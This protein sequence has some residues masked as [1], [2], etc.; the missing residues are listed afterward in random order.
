M[1]NPILVRTFIAGISVSFLCAVVGVFIVARKMAFFVHAVSHSALTGVAIGYL[2]GTSPFLS[3]IGFGIIAGVSVS[4]LIEKSK[5]FVDTVIGIL[6]PFTMSIGLILLSFVRGY[7]PDV[8]SYLF[9]D[10]LSTGKRDLLLLIVIS[11][12]VISLIALFLKTFILIALDRDFAKIKGYK[13]EMLD[14]LF[15]FVVSLVVLLATKVVGIILVSALVVIPAATAMNVSKSLKETFWLSILFGIFGTALGIFISYM[16]N[17]PTGPAI[18]SIISI[19]FL[20][21][22]LFKRN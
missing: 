5:L 18:V 2:L 3:S 7:K 20:L 6:L 16:F 19:I 9:G 21:S 10:I 1:M 15:M 14:Y 4:Y 8:M 12:F 13:V 11:I 17:L 22:F